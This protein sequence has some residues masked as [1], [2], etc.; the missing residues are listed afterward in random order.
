VLGSEVVNRILIFCEGGIPSVNTILKNF[1]NMKSILCVPE[2][3]VG[4]SGCGPIWIMVYLFLRSGHIQEAIVYMRDEVGKPEFAAVL[5]EYA[6]FEAGS[7]T[8]GLPKEIEAQIRL[9]YLR[10]MRNDGTDPYKR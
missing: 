2:L 3:E 6:K 7:G 5:S 10:V 1:V 9:E 4:P 8:L